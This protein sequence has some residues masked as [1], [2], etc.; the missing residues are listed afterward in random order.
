V[1]ARLQ[2]RWWYALT[3]ETRNEL[4][5][6]HALL[7]LGLGSPSLGIGRQDEE[8]HSIEECR[9]AEAVHEKEVVFMS[10]LQCDGSSVEIR[11]WYLCKS[12]C[13]Q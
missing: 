13:I 7:R 4:H 9:H 1:R 5:R 11:A 2:H 12:P 3:T 8:A 6:T 10:T